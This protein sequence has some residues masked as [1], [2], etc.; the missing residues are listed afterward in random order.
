MSYL[1]LLNNKKI[2]YGLLLFLIFLLLKT[3]NLIE[4]NI[5]NGTEFIKNN[6]YTSIDKGNLKIIS[7]NIKLLPFNI[8][9]INKIDKIT[10]IIK[11]E[12][13]DI[14]CIQECFYSFYNTRNKFYKSLK[15]YNYIFSTKE[16]FKLTCGGVVLL[17]KYNFDE[18]KYIP[19]QNSSFPDSFSNK[20]F[21]AVRI[22]DIWVIGLH[23]QSDVFTL[24]NIEDIQYKQ[25]KQITNFINI[26]KKKKYKIILLG[27]FNI[28]INNE[29]N[30][31]KLED[32]IPIKLYYTKGVTYEDQYIDL[33]FSNMHTDIKIKTITD[34]ISD[35]NM[36]ISNVKI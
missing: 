36:I 14:I 4:N 30:K 17:S 33:L 18:Y 29:T 35:H 21:I 11:S 34:D 10:N 8:F 3:E 2:I 24:F 16:R 12:D 28:D 32:L 26:I 5:N 13:P 20:G 22:R 19:F 6:E 9:N 7:W 25:I 27:D 1:E 15:D 31:K 23:L